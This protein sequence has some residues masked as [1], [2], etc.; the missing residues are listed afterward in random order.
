MVANGQAVPAADLAGFSLRIKGT[1]FE[2]TTL[3]GTDSGTFKLNEGSKPKR[4]DAAAGDGG[5]IPAIYEAG[6]DTFKVCYAVNGA[7]RPT[8]FKSESGSDHVYVVYR[9]KGAKAAKSDLDQLQ[10]NWTPT[11]LVANGERVSESDLTAFKVKV[12]GNDY[13]TESPQGSDEGTF[14]L[15]ETFSPKR[16]DVSSKSGTELPAIYEVSGDSFKACY[17]VNGA[18]RPT[19]FRST[20]GSDHVLI[21]Y[22]RK[23]N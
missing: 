2:V 10:G 6:V 12:K 5:E 1:S 14:K 13:Q 15:L 16:M 9:R 18:P 11:E 19:E 3:Q 17:A 23:A 8:A 4:M 22:K 7:S 21:V 20:S